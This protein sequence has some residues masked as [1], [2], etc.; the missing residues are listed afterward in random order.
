VIVEGL[1]AT[2]ELAF[3]AFVA[4]VVLGALVG[5]VRARVRAPM[6]RGVFAIAQLIGRA[7]PVIV[8]ALFL[9]LL[10]GVTGVLPV[11]GIASTENF[12]L[13]DRI[14][15]LILP[16]LCLAVPFGAWASTIFFDFFRTEDD[17]FGTPAHGIVSPLVQSAA[18]IGPALLSA[19]ILIEP[20]FAWPGF[21]RV[22]F[23]GVQRFDSAVV[24]GC[25][26]FYCT[27]IVLIGLLADL[28]PDVRDAPLPRATASPPRPAG[29]R[30]RIGAT[31]A[32][33]GAVLVVAVFGALVA[34]AAPFGPYFIDQGHWVGY[35]L[36][37]GV[38]GH[39]L[40]T[41]ENGRDL[42][43]RV[44]VGLRTSLG[45]AALAALFAA[46][47]GFVA[48]RAT[49]TL[50][51]RDDRTAA[52]LAGIRPFA[53]FPFVLAAVALLVMR[54]HG[55]HVLN[56]FVIALIIGAVSWPAAV[57]LFRTLTPGTLAGT[58]DLMACALLIEV[59][60]SFFGLGVQPPTPSLG[61]M[62]VNAQS[63]AVVAPWIPIVPTVVMIV[64]LFALYAVAAELRNTPSAK[65]F[66]C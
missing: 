57:P 40:G 13:G 14:S 25:L 56:P 34:N 20:L 16:V 39:A 24:A 46:A 53:G 52:A 44:L 19:S 32:V 10:L 43:A 18:L 45:I 38:A 26:L 15:H 65:E 51:R 61:N 50:R 48:A 35:P 33:A 30:K 5:F 6:L 55:T 54:S 28:A 58:V 8:L 22:F 47:I 1:P 23:G 59:T 41:D 42:L 31:G 4:S 37:P 49:T 60:Q 7:A 3:V 12:E 62:L 17:A 11:A 36:A 66:F 21:A 64:T 63:N 9:Q 2:I 27:A 29:G